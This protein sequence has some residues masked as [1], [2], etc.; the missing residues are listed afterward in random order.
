[1]LKK[2]ITYTN[3]ANEEVTETHYFNLSKAELVDMELSYPYAGGLSEYIKKIAEEENGPEI[4]AMFK[5]LL[6]QTYGK[7]SEDG[8]RF[9]K[10]DAIWEDFVTSEAYSELF[11]KLVT[12][13]EAAAEF[14]NGVV[15]QISEAERDKILKT[16]LVET[17]GDEKP[18]PRKL[19][20]EDLISMD[21][22]EVKKGLAEGRY[23]V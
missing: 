18:A 12:D 4:M 6:R 15:P 2:D 17:N 19:T 5:K 10:S 20:H 23:T 3:F 14:F 21:N 16:Q 7:K 9:L 8:R 13:A 11:F 1:M 22:E